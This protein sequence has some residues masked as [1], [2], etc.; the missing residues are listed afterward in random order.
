MAIKTIISG[1]FIKDSYVKVAD[2]DNE[3]I[4]YFDTETKNFYKYN[5]CGDCWEVHTITPEDDFIYGILMD[6]YKKIIDNSSKK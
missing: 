5:N 1:L 3:V 4:Y 6:D 2:Y